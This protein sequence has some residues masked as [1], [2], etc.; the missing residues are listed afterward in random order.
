VRL[1]LETAK[2]NNRPDS[3]IYAT[4]VGLLKAFDS[5]FTGFDSKWN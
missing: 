4:A 1:V 5:K 2:S 3:D